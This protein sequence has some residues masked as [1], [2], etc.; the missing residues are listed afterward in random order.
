MG[1]FDAEKN[2]FLVFENGPTQKITLQWATYQ[3]ASD[4][5]S[6]SR[7]WGG[8]HPPID[9]IPGRKIGHQVGI[10]AFEKAIKYF[11]GDPN[12]KEKSFEVAVYPTPI[13]PFENL[14]IIYQE[15]IQEAVQFQLFDLSGRLL[16]EKVIKKNNEEVMS[17]NVCTP[18]KGLYILIANS[19]GKR[20]FSKKILVR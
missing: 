7:I 15:P 6:L 17:F 3:D 5:C 9:D 11:Q 8:I 16:C 2:E 14:Q 20:L 18:E 13:N 12:Q 19:N 10:A 1:E 4:Q